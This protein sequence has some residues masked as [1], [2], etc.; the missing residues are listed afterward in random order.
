MRWFGSIL[1]LLLLATKA[2]ALV[3][4]HEDKAFWPYLPDPAKPIEGKPGL[5]L[6]LI[7]NAAEDINLDVQ[8]EAM[9]W[10][11]CL[12]NLETGKIDAAFA[13]IWTEGRDLKFRFPKPKRHTESS[14]FETDHSRAL[15]FA[16]YPIF[17]KVGSDLLWDGERFSNVKYGLSGP[18]GYVVHKRLKDMG[19]LYESDLLPSRGLHLVSIDRLDG[20]VLERLIGSHIL[21]RLQVSSVVTPFAR[22]FMRSAWFLPVSNA[23]YEQQPNVAE[24]LWDALQ[25]SRIELE[26]SLEEKYTRSLSPSIAH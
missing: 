21:G 13:V 12:A 6:D 8:F 3:L 19:V 2:E 15:W 9:P 1:L 14:A 25:E 23:F 16:E 10:K 11:R 5:L 26:H 4:C 22:N 7:R 20:Y 17:T 18:P 24:A